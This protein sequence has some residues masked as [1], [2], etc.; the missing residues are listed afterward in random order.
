MFPGCQI[1]LD[2]P[3]RQR[4]N[5]DK[6]NLAALALNPEMHHALAAL[7]VPQPQQAQLLA[8][9]AVIEEGSQYCAIPN[10]LQ[11]SRAGAASSLRTWASPKAGVLP[12]F[13]FAAG[14]STPS[15]GFPTTAFRSQR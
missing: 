1:L 3:L 10:T 14:R 2:Q 6:P 9:D 12:S 15:T 11:L 4:M 7:H 5:G 8:P 13:P